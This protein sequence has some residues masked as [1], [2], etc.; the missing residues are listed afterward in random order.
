MKLI[1]K[2]KAG[3]SLVALGAMMLTSTFTSNA[4]STYTQKEKDYND[5][6]YHHQANME[7]RKNYLMY[8][9]VHK[10]QVESDNYNLFN[11]ELLRKEALDYIN[12]DYKVINLEMTSNI[13]NE[14]LKPRNGLLFNKGIL[15]MDDYINPTCRLYTVKCSSS[16]YAAFKDFVVD[17]NWRKCGSENSYEYYREGYKFINF[18]YKPDKEVLY[19][20]EIFIDRNK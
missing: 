4:Q 13:L 8:C 15:A 17:E 1:K 16:D 5:T 2:L 18:V 11:D 3:V 19:V 9:E 10:F 12:R 14:S 6:S 20:I 7:D